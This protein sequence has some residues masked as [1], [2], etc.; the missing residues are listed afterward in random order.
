MTTPLGTDIRFRIGDRPVN[1]QDGDASKARTDHGVIL[2]DREIEIPAGAVRV[3]PLEET[4]RGTIAFPPSQ[5]NGD[6]VT[7]LK[8][9]FV[10]GRVL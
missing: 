5:W 6:P 7:G 9:E 8:L 2:I 10:E 1:R 3:A 4:V